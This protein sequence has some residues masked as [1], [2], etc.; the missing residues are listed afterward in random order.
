M[1]RKLAVAFA[2]LAVFAFALN[3]ADSG[4]TG[5]WNFV[6]DTEGGERQ[7]PAEFGLDGKNVTGNFAGTEVK[8]TFDEARL[9]LK[10]SFESEEVGKGT[11]VFK[12]KLDGGA[13]VGDFSFETEAQTYSGTFKATHPE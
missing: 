4:V 13:L 2:L 11:L 12:G 9:E 6:L 1:I 10:F 3:A 8:G 7:A 5:K